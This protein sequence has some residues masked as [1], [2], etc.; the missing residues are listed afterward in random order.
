MSQT[1][2]PTTVNWHLN[3]ACTM[4]CRFCF[5][6]FD[7]IPEDQLIRGLPRAKELLT[8]L[9][10]H[11][12]KITL[13]GGE[14]LLCPFIIELLGVCKALG[15]STCLVSNGSELL[16]RPELV[17][18]LAPVLDTFG[19]SIDSARPE[20]LERLGRATK[21]GA[22]RPEQY[23]EIAQR[24]HAAGIRLKMNVVVNRLNFKEDMRWFID[25]LA[26]DR[27]KFFQVLPVLDQN[28]DEIDDLIIS[29]EEF[30]EF[31]TL[32]HGT[33][34]TP[35]PESNDLMYGSYA[36]VD[37]AGRFFDSTTGLYR[38]SEPIL[39]VGLLEAFSQVAFSNVKFEERGGRY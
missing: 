24:L 31:Q 25:A 26:P 33:R 36:M 28:G 29:D 19:I 16:R 38:Y 17:K 15:R 32:N 27:L 34:A 1:P 3:R 11:F 5:G 35:I 18:Q 20:V 10:M 30:L 21:S 9:S 12:Q 37:P 14:P 23:I 13:T 4:K 39:L 6:K 22:L 8:V 7:D 2:L